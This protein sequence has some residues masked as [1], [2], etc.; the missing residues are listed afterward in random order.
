MGKITTVGLDLAKQVMAVHAIDAEG[1]V[2][3]RKVLR[4][5]ALLRWTAA[6]PACVVAMKS[7]ERDRATFANHCRGRPHHCGRHGSNRR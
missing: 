1:R 3:L 5:D 4:R 2:V 7:A 6:L